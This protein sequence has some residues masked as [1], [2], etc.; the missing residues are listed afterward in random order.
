MD[1]TKKRGLTMIK[2][3]WKRTGQVEMELDWPHNW[4]LA[5]ATFIR[6]SQRI[7]DNKE[8]GQNMSV[9]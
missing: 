9:R 4:I 7:Y 3:Y 8:R 1:A 2:K 6:H 5:L